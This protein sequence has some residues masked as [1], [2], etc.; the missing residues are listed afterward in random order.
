[1]LL[2]YNFY[3]W[4]SVDPK[5]LSINIIGYFFFINYIMSSIFLT[6]DLIVSIN[7]ALKSNTL[8]MR[9]SSSFSLMYG[10]KS[11]KV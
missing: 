4:L 6:P 11:K 3:F 8:V 1:M 9:I 2:Y 7:V 10:E 5:H